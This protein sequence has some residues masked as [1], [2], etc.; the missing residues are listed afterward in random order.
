MA[1][2]IAQARE[3]THLV[4]AKDVKLDRDKFHYSDCLLS[5]SIPTRHEESWGKCLE[6]IECIRSRAGWRGHE[7]WIDREV[8]GEGCIRTDWKDH[9]D[10]ALNSSQ[11][12][13]IFV[14][15]EGIAGNESLEWEFDRMNDEL[16]QEN[17]IYIVLSGSERHDQSLAFINAS[18][19]GSIILDNELYTSAQI[20]DIIVALPWERPGEI[21]QGTNRLPR[22]IL[23]PSEPGLSLRSVMLDTM[24]WPREPLVY[25]LDDVLQTP[26]C[27]ALVNKA[28]A[29]NFAQAPVCACSKSEINLTLRDHKRVAIDDPELATLLF[30]RL[31]SNLPPQM[32][33][34][35][36]LVGLNPRIRWLRYDRG[37]FVK[38]HRDG[39]HVDSNGTRS[40]LSL[41]IYL[42]T[43]EGLSGATRF[44]PSW[45]A[46][47][48]GRPY[49]DV[50]P[51]AGRVCVMQQDALHESVSVNTG[52]KFCLRTD[53]MYE[54]RGMPSKSN[55]LDLG[56][57]H[58]ACGKLN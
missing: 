23:E 18:C 32:R 50:T 52:T 25:S 39:A 48:E 58:G 17:M 19:Q 3:F 49:L 11:R 27:E 34:G 45:T 15:R 28:L 55:G 29:L 54:M 6:I 43:M 14:G 20:A 7:I 47:D 13:L 31:R 8:F 1:A 9:W 2:S 46:V 21:S 56:K 26:E 33:D 38:V 10:A 22:F 36:R 37:E 44:Y 35:S 57:D 30:R 4:P 53:V 42:N 51:S 12:G 16:S 40:A 5:A 41:L 24:D